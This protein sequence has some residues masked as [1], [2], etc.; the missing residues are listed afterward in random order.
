MC[1]FCTTN[2]ASFD[3]F[4]SNSFYLLRYLSPSQSPSFPFLLGSLFPSLPF[5]PV[6]VSGGL[7]LQDSRRRLSP[8]SPGLWLQAS[9]LH[10]PAPDSTP[11]FCDP[12]VTVGHEAS[13]VVSSMSFIFFEDSEHFHITRHGRR[14]RL[15]R[16]GV[17]SVRPM[18]CH[19]RPS[20]PLQHSRSFPFTLTL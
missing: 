5:S 17:S 19:S 12:A 6:H 20:Q 15:K 7:H 1:L 11:L 4:C 8:R 18:S 14:A 10:P 16:K 13:D 3:F 2:R 9:P